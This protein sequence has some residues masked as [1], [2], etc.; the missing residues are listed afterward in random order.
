MNGI[1]PENSLEDPSLGKVILQHLLSPRTWIYPILIL[2]IAF[3]VLPRL[4][5][6]TDSAPKSRNEETIFFGGNGENP[7]TVESTD[8]EGNIYRFTAPGDGK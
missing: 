8:A 4:N 3:F 5:R 2:I 1:K 7:G 6:Q